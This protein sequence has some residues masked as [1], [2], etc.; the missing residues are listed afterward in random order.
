[1]RALDAAGGEG[2]RRLAIFT[3]FLPLFLFPRQMEDGSAPN[4]TIDSVRVLKSKD[5]G[6]V[7]GV[8]GPYYFA[9]KYK[10]DPR[11][12]P[13]MPMAERLAS[14]FYWAVGADSA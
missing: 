14:G 6:L 1:M 4:V 12:D 5:S 13:S 2:V 11:A 9:A 10:S 3:D 8:K 7:I